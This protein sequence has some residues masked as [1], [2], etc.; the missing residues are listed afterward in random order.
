LSAARRPSARKAAAEASAH[1]ER[2]E[3]W[4]GLRVGDRVVVAGLPTR[5]ATWEF[6]AHVRNTHNGSESVEVVGGRPG[7][8]TV[9]SVGPERIFAAT[10]SKKRKSPTA[11]V[12]RDQLSLADAPQLP[13][14]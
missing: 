12:F 9:R 4:N 6:R 1:L 3:A 13:L 7:E 2:S 10:G 14:G 11:G 5:G 8:R